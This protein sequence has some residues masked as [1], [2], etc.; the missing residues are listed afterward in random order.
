LLV[1]VEP[2]AIEAVVE[3]VVVIELQLH[4]NFPLALRIP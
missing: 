2:L 3:A 4:H 1:A